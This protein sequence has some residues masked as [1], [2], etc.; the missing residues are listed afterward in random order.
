MRKGAK[1]T[2]SLPRALLGA[3]E[4]ERKRRGESRSQFFRRAAQNLVR[5]E[6]DR[7]AEARYVRGYRELPEQAAEMN[8]VERVALDTLANEPWK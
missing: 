3:A 4:R 6:T 5:M 8:S 2:I 1:I 7:E